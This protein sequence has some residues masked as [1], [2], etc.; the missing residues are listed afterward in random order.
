M[1]RINSNM[2]ERL[3]WL[4]AVKG[5]GILLIMWSHH[6][7]IEWDYWYILTMA[8]IT[9]FFL[10]S[11]IMIKG[12]DVDMSKKAKRLLIPYFFYGIL[13]FVADLFI[14]KLTGGEMGGAKLWGLLYG[15]ISYLKSYSE[16]NILLIPYLRPL[17]FLPCMFAAYSYYKI[18]LLAVKISQMLG[19]AV[20]SI[21]L[22][23]SLYCVNI[24]YQLPFSLDSAGLMCLFLFLGKELRD[25]IHLKGF[26]IALCVAIF[27]V[28]ALI[29]GDVNI[30]VCHYGA[31]GW[32]SVFLMI[33]ISVLYFLIITN[34]FKRHESLLLVRM[35]AFLGRHSLRLMCIHV[36]IFAIADDFLYRMSLNLFIIDLPIVIFMVMFIERIVQ[37]CK[38][39]IPI[40]SYI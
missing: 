12:K 22:L 30:S 36:F 9:L 17:W 6:I 32:R 1:Q 4:D 5:Y 15:K 2:K 19:Y 26:L 34:I 3:I 24:P 29:N 10:T 23:L 11:G 40:L 8:Y 16:E 28:L 14:T 25:Y 37:K 21:F 20:L 27:F 39:R 18:Y 7:D 35:F 33:P 13:F 38:D 31:L